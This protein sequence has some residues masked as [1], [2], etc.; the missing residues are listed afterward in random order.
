MRGLRTQHGWNLSYLLS[1]W[2]PAVRAGT[3]HD[4]EL[5]AIV[6]IGVMGRFIDDDL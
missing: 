4:E 3:C 1:R 6:R 5:K 2:M